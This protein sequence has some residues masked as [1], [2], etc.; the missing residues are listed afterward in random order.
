VSSPEVDPSSGAAQ[1]GLR[2]R[3]V[4]EHAVL[5]ECPT[6]AEVAAAYAR[7][8]AEVPDAVDVV[9]AARTVLVTGVADPA[10]L[11]ERVRGWRLAATDV[12]A[13]DLVEVPVRYDGADL[14]DVAA[15]WGVS[16]R[17]AVRL[18]RDR[19]YVVAFCGFAPGFAYCAGLPEPLAVPR[20]DSPR[21]RVPAGAVAVAGTWTGIYPSASPGGWRLLGTTEAVLWQVD[22][23][24]PALLAPG[25]RLRFVE[26]AG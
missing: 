15:H 6:G 4:G 19:E 25:T 24:P 22:R 10:G 2:G 17:E 13:G 16:P 14:A 9:P 12:P 18:H 1:A 7:A 20:L 21:T 11:A 3:V 23:D 26:V 5:V 8:R